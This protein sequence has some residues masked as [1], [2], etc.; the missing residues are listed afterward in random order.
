MLLKYSVKLFFIFP[1][2][3]IPH[4]NFIIQQQTEKLINLKLPIQLTTKGGEKM[5]DVITEVVSE[6]RQAKGKAWD[7]NG[8][9]ELINKALNTLKKNKKPIYIPK[10]KIMTFYKGTGKDEDHNTRIKRKVTELFP[11]LKDKL[12]F[13]EVTP[14]GSD[15]SI[16]ALKI[17]P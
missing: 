5:E 13:V 15:K 17:N 8:L 4:K 9:T 6:K 12:E 10:N 11:N 7:T 16:T 3:T 14:K 2:L 1:L